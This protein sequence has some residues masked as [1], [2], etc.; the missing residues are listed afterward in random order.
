MECFTVILPVFQIGKKSLSKYG[1]SNGEA[2]QSLFTISN[3]SKDPSGIINLMKVL[4]EYL[5]P[6]SSTMDLWKKSGRLRHRSVRTKGQAMNSEVKRKGAR[7]N[8]SKEEYNVTN[9]VLVPESDTI[10]TNILINGKFNSESNPIVFVEDKDGS[11]KNEVGIWVKMVCPSYSVISQH[12]KELSL[13]L[14]RRDV[15]QSVPGS[16]SGAG[17]GTGGGAGSKHKATVAGQES[18]IVTE[19]S[20]AVDIDSNVGNQLRL[21]G[22]Y[23]IWQ[24]VSKMT[25]YCCI[26][27]ISLS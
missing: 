22:L 20:K 19:K 14:L 24:E 3:T 27:L 11:D 21:E 9:M 12:S 23:S 6:N 4:S 17:S 15:S 8:V 1:E 10:E 18:S 7:G 26:Y 2:F 5:S 25:L 16:G 13:R